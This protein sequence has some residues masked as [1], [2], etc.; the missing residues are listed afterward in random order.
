MRV[1]TVR[2]D[3]VARTVGVVGVVGGGGGGAR[4]AHRGAA[5]AH[6]SVHA[7]DAVERQEAPREYELWADGWRAQLV[8]CDFVIAIATT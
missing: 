4:G 8:I 5:T 6:V 1:P 2:E 7:R 3:G